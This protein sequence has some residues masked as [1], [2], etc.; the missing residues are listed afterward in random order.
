MSEDNPDCPECGSELAPMID[1]VMGHKTSA[2]W[3]CNDCE[4]WWDWEDW[5]EVQ[6]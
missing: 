2:G 3:E 5:T 6:E 4:L 1:Y